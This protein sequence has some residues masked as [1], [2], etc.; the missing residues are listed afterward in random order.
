M[1]LQNE[2]Q[3]RRSESSLQFEKEAKITIKIKKEES[4]KEAP[5]RQKAKKRRVKNKEKIIFFYQC[6]KHFMT[7]YGMNT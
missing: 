2:S 7:K 1:K 3:A 5:K 4:K 6:P